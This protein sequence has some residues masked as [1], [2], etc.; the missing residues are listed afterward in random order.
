M[1]L[2]RAFIVVRDFLRSRVMRLRLWRQYGRLIVA[3]KLVTWLS[4]HGARPF[5]E[6]IGPLVAGGHWSRADFERYLDILEGRIRVR[7]PWQH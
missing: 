5:S 2:L 3:I 1:R 4:R 6:R 7:Q